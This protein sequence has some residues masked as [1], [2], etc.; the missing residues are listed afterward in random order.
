MSDTFTHPADRLLA[1]G[2]ALRAE[3]V[4]LKAE[5]ARL[6]EALEPYAYASH[7]RI[8]IG[9]EKPGCELRV[10]VS[11][12]AR[13]IRALTHAEV[14]AENVAASESALDGAGHV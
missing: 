4:R 7:R 13:A 9:N 14:A 5:N 1:E 2:E 11:D 12:H 6:R 8:H 3:I 10:W